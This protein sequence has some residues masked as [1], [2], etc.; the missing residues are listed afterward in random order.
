VPDKPLAPADAAGCVWHLFPVF[1]SDGRRD[2][3]GRHLAESGVQSGVHYPALITDQLALRE[4]GRYH[5]H[6]SL[7]RARHLVQTELSLPIHPYLTDEEA[8]RVAR[9]MQDWARR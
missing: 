4:H 6:G 1:V 3:L 5:V 9:A 2:E 7:D 8:G